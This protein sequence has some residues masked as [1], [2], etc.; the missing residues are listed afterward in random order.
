M[1]KVVK[2]QLK[3][4]KSYPTPKR[5]KQRLLLDL[6]RRQVSKVRKRIVKPKHVPY[7]PKHQK[8][9]DSKKARKSR[10][11]WCTSLTALARMTEKQTIT[12]LQ[13]IDHLEKLKNCPHCTKGKLGPLKWVYGRGWVQR[14][15][16]FACQ[17]FVSPHAN[18]PVYSNADGSSAVKLNTQAQVLFCRIAGASNSVTTK[19]TG[20]SQKLVRGVNDRWLK[21]VKK[22]VLKEQKKIKFGNRKQHSSSIPWCQCEV[23]EVTL[24]GKKIA[25]RRIRWLQYCG[26]LR[27]GDRKSLVLEK[28]K[29]KI[30]RLKRK[31]KGKGQ[32]ASPGAI[33][34]KEWARIG[35]RWLKKRR[36]LLH[37][38]GARSY[39]FAK[40]PG[41]MT[42]RVRHKRPNPIYAARRL[43]FLPHDQKL[44]HT[45]LKDKSASQKRA[46][47]RTWVKTGTQLIDNFWRQLKTK[48]IPKEMTI[49]EGKIDEYVREYQWRHWG[50]GE[51]L[52]KKAGA[53]MHSAR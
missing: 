6:A 12:H 15:G 47:T 31:G 49:L 10:Q 29:M 8:V 13:N 46:V 32:P 19:I 43:M 14:C 23:D 3:T 39:K 38:D 42:T 45:R 36:I 35:P 41:V 44:A 28:M 11:S 37:C 40:I 48:G 34:K 9:D 21:T 50:A 1:P 5:G 18:H 7:I 16:K 33:S 20:A 2:Q 24:K 22:H 52:W 53:V 25:K 51:D 17:N 26:L 30:T 4:S 27:R